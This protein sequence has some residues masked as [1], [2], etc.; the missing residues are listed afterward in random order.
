MAPFPVSGNEEDEPGVFEA[1]RRKLGFVWVTSLSSS[2]DAGDDEESTPTIQPI[3]TMAQLV[4]GSDED[5]GVD[6]G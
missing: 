1:R 3:P 6:Y 4:L 2:K 5:D